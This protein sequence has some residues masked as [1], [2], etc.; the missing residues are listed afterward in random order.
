MLGEDKVHIDTAD[1][2]NMR[3]KKHDYEQKFINMPGNKKQ[4][5]FQNRQRN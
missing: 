1:I 5:S 4:Q 3:E 2:V